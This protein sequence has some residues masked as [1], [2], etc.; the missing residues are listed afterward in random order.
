MLFLRFYV[1]QFRVRNPYTVRGGYLGAPAF[2]L[3]RAVYLNTAPL[4]PRKL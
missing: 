4:L 2:V 3:V 1:T